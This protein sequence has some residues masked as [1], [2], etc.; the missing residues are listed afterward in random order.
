MLFIYPAAG[1]GGKLMATVWVKIK[2]KYEDN[3]ACPEY[4][5]HQFV[6]ND[7]FVA[8]PSLKQPCKRLPLHFSIFALTAAGDNRVCKYQDSHKFWYLS[9]APPFGI[10]KVNT[11]A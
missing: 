2:V 9:L 8:A 3:D 5:K 4:G 7:P 1:A 10:I 6:D 11:K